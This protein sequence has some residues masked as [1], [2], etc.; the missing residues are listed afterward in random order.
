MGD[1]LNLGPTPADEP[2]AQVGEEGYELKARAECQRYI[3]LLRRKF[4]PEPP[5]SKLKIRGFQHD[6][7]RYFEC[8]VTYRDGD[9]E[10]FDYALKLEE[11]APTRWEE[12]GDDQVRAEDVPAPRA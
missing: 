11:E 4:G 8:I 7:G 6:F 10:A 1:Y 5:G 3:E 2:C 9:Q 12:H